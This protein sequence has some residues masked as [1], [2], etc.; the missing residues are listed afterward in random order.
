[1]SVNGNKLNGNVYNNNWFDQETLSK[2]A[3]INFDM[4]PL[5][6]KQRGTQPSSFP[7]SLSNDK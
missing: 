5:A 6:N 3:V 7:Y 2:G 4:K 1:M